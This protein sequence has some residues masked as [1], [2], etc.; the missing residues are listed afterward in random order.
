ML[1]GEKKTATQIYILNA[2][3]NEQKKRENKKSNILIFGLPLSPATTATEKEVHD[4][5]RVCEIFSDMGLKNID[6]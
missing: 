1:I 2:V 3:G 4:K 6:V 5:K